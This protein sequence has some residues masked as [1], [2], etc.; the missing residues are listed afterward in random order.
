MLREV[1]TRIESPIFFSQSTVPRL[2]HGLFDACLHRGDDR[3][4]DC[5]ARQNEILI[6]FAVD[7]TRAEFLPWAKEFVRM[8]YTFVGTP[9]T[10][11]YFCS[12]GVS[13][14]RKVS[15]RRLRHAIV[16]RER[17]WLDN[18]PVPHRRES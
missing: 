18:N 5:D 9:G 7:S 14:S 16:L 11:D 2:D 8:G 17:G 13:T 1:D 4:G 6:S 15:C 10:A 12:N 3:D